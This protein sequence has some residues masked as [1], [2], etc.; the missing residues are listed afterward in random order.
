MAA[1]T[2]SAPSDLEQFLDIIWEPGD[3]R[4]VR[5]PGPRGTD[6]GYFDDPSK[7]RTAV[8]RYDGREN[9]YVTINPVEPARAVDH[10]GRRRDR[11]AVAANRP[12]SEAAVG[13][14]RQ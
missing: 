4:E 14:Q 9:L 13:H 11:P 1:V 3:V 7:L 12:G 5:I 8:A 2:V 6:A 10:G